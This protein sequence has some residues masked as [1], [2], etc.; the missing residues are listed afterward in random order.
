MYV[1]ANLYLY[2]Y[3]T[4]FFVKD[5]HNRCITKA[6]KRRERKRERERKGESLEKNA[7]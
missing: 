5:L 4:V 1:Q 3:F 7:L 2:V 6:E